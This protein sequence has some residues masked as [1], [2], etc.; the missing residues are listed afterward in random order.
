MKTMLKM[1]RYSVS[2]GT[3]SI[4]TSKS[5]TV[6]MNPGSFKHDQ[7]ILYDTKCAFGQAGVE[8]KFNTI[9]P[10]T[11]GFDITL[12][13]TGAVPPVTPGGSTDSVTQQLQKL[14]GV[15]YAYVGDQ[16][17][18][19][20]V[21]LLWGTLIFFGRMKSMSTEYTLFKSSGDPL[22]AKVSLSFFGTMSKEENA[23]VSNRSS[24]DLNHRIVVRQGDTLPLLCH[25]IY[26]DSGY[27]REVARHNKLAHFRRLTPGATLDFPPLK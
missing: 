14:R 20:R 6:M 18:P 15:V 19:S 2:N 21:R 17:E 5:F 13:G 27:Y 11:V 12:D 24:P 16:H 9:G 4:D 7:E 26:G 3:V 22:R 8:P 23:L 10:D 25:R 1:T